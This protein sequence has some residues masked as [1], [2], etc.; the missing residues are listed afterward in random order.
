MGSLFWLAIANLFKFTRLIVYSMA[1]VGGQ[2]R[3]G[4]EP[5]GKTSYRVR[6][7]L[8]QVV[9]FHRSS[10]ANLGKDRGSSS[11]EDSSIF[12]IQP[13]KDIATLTDKKI[14]NN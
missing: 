3:H 7:M 5:K 9:F 10:S 2:Y 6:L 12:L 4:Y 1:K 13:T 8:D 14:F 11:R